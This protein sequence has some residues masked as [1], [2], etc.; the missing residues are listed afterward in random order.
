MI[1]PEN[2]PYRILWLGVAII[3]AIATTILLLSHFAIG[4]W[5]CIPDIGGDGAKNNFTYLYHS[6][7]GKGLWFTGMDYPHG[8]HI[9]YTD[10]PLLS[11]IM[12]SIGHVTAEQA[13]AFQ[14]ISI[15]L[16]YAIAIVF[17]YLTLMHFRVRP[18]LAVIFSCLIIVFTPQLLRIEGHNGLSF[19]CIIPMLFYWTLKYHERRRLKYSIYMYLV[20]IIYAFIH[21][22]F[23]AMVLIWASLYV[24]GYFIL[25]R[26]SIIE[27]VKHTLPL[28]VTAICVLLTWAAVV[29]ATDPIKDRPKTPFTTIYWN[30]RPRQIITSYISPVSLLAKEKGIIGVI[31]PKDEGY[32]YIGV[33]IGLTIAVSFFIAIWKRYIK[34]T[35]ARLVNEEVFPAI[36]LFVAFAALLFSMGVPFIWKMEWLY[37]YLS[38][39]KQ[40]RSLGRFSWIFYYIIAVYTAVM[41]NTAFSRLQARK[42][43]LAAWALVLF[44][45]GLWS[46]EASGYVRFSRQLAANGVYNY[47]MMF[48]K[49][50]QNWAS[51][52]K[53]HNYSSDSFQALL[54][55]PYYHVGT[56]KLWVGDPGWVGTLGSKSGLQLQLPIIDAYLARTSWSQAK[57]QVKLVAGPYVSKPLLTDIKSRKPFLLLH[58]PEDRIDE[59]QRY[60]LEACEFIG[61]YSQ[62]NVYACYPDRLAANDKKH[63]DMINNL[64]PQLPVGDT[65]LA[66][67]GTWYVEHF[68]NNATTHLFGKGAVKE[69]NIEDTLIASI[70]ITNAADSQRYEFSCWVLL[71]DKDY[72]S[73][74]FTL[75]FYN[76]GGVQL[77]TC[78]VQTI[79]SV[80]SYHMW[81]RTSRYFNMPP[82]CTMVK[83]T[84]N[85]V[86]KHSY[87]YMDELMLRP[88]DA[89]IISKDANGRV[90]VNNHFFN[91]PKEAY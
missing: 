6:L 82:G 46:Y 42:K 4:P 44:A 62:C 60:L 41:I 59:D 54:L 28:F 30:T 33:I 18:A 71:D 10:E 56:E 53:E 23:G 75:R 38:F 69:I 88:A 52:L 49:H 58:F 55:L 21:P 39:F 48:S 84:L 25:T 1:K 2:P 90:M 12:A 22:Y 68:D 57:K 89:L 37:D 65:C 76:K 16:S 87:H 8:D 31:P 17:V 64:L 32:V 27:K 34:K 15:S 77:D 13:L 81:F 83:C 29:K 67:K 78:L 63:A 47:E 3:F 14:W 61:F 11:V 91:A 43:I 79:N 80:D 20:G 66:N 19:A 26:Q 51:F 70:P 9:V 7:Y 72:S 36:W 74:D 45:V 40:F 5:G 24:A 73:P 50:E 85:R 35:S 86:K